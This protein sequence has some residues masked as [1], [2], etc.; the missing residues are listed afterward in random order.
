MLLIDGSLLAAIIVTGL[1]ARP[2]DGGVRRGDSGV[3]AGTAKRPS[4]ISAAFAALVLAVVGLGIS[5]AV[6]DK[7]A[8][9]QARLDPN[10]FEGPDGPTTNGENPVPPPPSDPTI[11]PN[12]LPI[13]NSWYAKD[14]VQGWVGK[15]WRDLELFQL[16]QRWPSGMDAAKK[17]VVFYRRDCEH[18]EAMF[19]DYLIVE[20]DAPVTAVEIPATPTEL[21]APD[22]WD[23]PQTP[24]EHL[25]LPLGCNY[26]ITPPLALTIENGKVTCAIEGDPEAYL[27]CLGL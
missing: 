11:N 24:V 10:G 6:P 4:L 18:C 1:A 9:Q 19:Y 8:K 7:A 22:A 23:M 21:R 5:F 26:L 27:Q 17:Y 25:Q 15:S 2:G 3:G 14:G 16:M 13:P 20:L 12:P